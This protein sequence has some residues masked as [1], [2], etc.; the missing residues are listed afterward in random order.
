M[1]LP[2]MDESARSEDMDIIRITPEKF[3]TVRHDMIPKWEK[4]IRQ[5][6]FEGKQNLGK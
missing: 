1:S 3:D 6:G 5:P 4:I 2:E